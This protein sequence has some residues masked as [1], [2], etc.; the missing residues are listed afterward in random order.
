MLAPSQDLRQSKC[1]S[2]LLSE[3]SIDK[4]SLSNNRFDKL[5]HEFC[6]LA[7]LSWAKL[8]VTYFTL[9]EHLTARVEVI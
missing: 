8:S 2:F 1:L 7:M 4:R 5:M 6:Q 9:N 3:L